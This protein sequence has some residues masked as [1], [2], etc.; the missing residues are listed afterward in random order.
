MT[1]RAS[2]TSAFVNHCFSPSAETHCERPSWRRWAAIAGTDVV[3]RS[4]SAGSVISAS[5]ATPAAP[6][7][8]SN[9]LLPQ[10]SR[11]ACWRLANGARPSTSNTSAAAGRPR[12]QHPA[13]RPGQREE[14]AQH[15]HEAADD[16][17]RS[18][19]F[20]RV[21]CPVPNGSRDC[22]ALARAKPGVG[23]A[24]AS[25]CC[26]FGAAWAGQFGRTRRQKNQH[27]CPRRRS[28]E[29]VSCNSRRTSTTRTPIFPSSTTISPRPISRGRRRSPPARRSV[30]R[31]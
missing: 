4:T 16:R 8:T 20:R 26:P 14:D 11:C 24:D 23:S 29:C 5:G 9:S 18:T 17:E 25:A 22:A 21:S 10:R 6:A 15:Q 30:R 2:R 19:E 1:L 3:K 27:D 7:D 13:K 31:A 12:R 28:H